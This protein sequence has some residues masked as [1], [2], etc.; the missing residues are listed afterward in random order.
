MSAA[1]APV[2]LLGADEAVEFALALHS[3]GAEVA[4]KAFLGDLLTEWKRRTGG[5][6]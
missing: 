5:E 3:S 6:A 4:S 2:Q 1:A